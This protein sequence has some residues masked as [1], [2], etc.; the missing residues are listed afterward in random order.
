MTGAH[1]VKTDTI[2]IG[3]PGT[4]LG[5]DGGDVVL[6]T[7]KVLTDN[8]KDTLTVKTRL[9]N[10]KVGANSTVEILDEP[11]R[12]VSIKVLSGDRSA[13]KLET[14]SR[15]VELGAGEQ[16]VIGESDRQGPDSGNRGETEQ[17]ISSFSIGKALDN[18]DLLANRAM[19]L[20]GTRR[21]DF[22]RLVAH[23]N[24]AAG[25]QSRDFQYLKMPPAQ[26]NASGRDNEPARVLAKPGTAFSQTDSGD[27]EL[28]TGTIF[29][30]AS[31]PVEIKTSLGSVQARGDSMVSVELRR[32]RLRVMSLSGP[33]AIYVLAGN[34][35]LD[36]SPGKEVLV[37]GHRPSRV[38]ALP[39]DGV[40]RR[41]LA[42]YA[43]D[44]KLAVVSGE[45]S[46]SS[47]LINMD[48]LRPL[49][50]PVSEANRRSLDRLIKLA[51]AVQVVS[52]RRGP[53]FVKPIEKAEVPDWL[54]KVEATRL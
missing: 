4:A 45:F 42:V 12:T 49:T 22:E 16:L 27:V 32:G 38:E 29:L 46:I 2:M 15:S 30:A 18:D 8:G 54:F 50:H 6:Y 5:A 20:S 1:G 39:A 44:K 28:M 25:S 52:A 11:G 47:M 31:Q 34:H 48:Y 19:R 40:G 3:A 9:G 35:K 17:R 24:Q 53:Y 37:V 36:L 33:N 10:V 26:S 41:Q 51:A 23:V 14:E 7:G 21:A 43:L 13:V